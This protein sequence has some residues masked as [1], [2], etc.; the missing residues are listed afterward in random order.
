M[1]ILVCGSRYYKNRNLIEKILNEYVGFEPTLIH[2]AAT[3]A[4]SLAGEVAE[5]FG[6]RT[7]AIPADWKKYGKA[8]GPIRNSEMLD[9][10]PDL[11]ISF[12]SGR[13]TTNCV[14]QAKNR[15]I[16]VREI[17]KGD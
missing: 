8:A 16:K 12:G 11:V 4:D 15:N 1:Y 9:F 5:D 2:G 13:G 17:D 3:G 10:Q 7:I 6:W 14:T